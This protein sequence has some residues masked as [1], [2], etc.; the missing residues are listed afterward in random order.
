[1][2]HNYSTTHDAKKKVFNLAHGL[3]VCS[4]LTLLLSGNPKL[5]A[6]LHFPPCDSD[7]LVKILASL[8]NHK[9]CTEVLP[10]LCERILNPLMPGFNIETLH[11]L[12][13]RVLH[14]TPLFLH[15]C[16]VISKQPFSFVAVYCVPAAASFRLQLA[17]DACFSSV[18]NLGFICL[19]CCC[20]RWWR[21]TRQVTLMMV[22]VVVVVMIMLMMTM[23]TSFYL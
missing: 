3:T 17:R 18:P 12:P 14:S 8:P 15:L 16:L 1:M 11:M 13:V 21:S 4:V 19:L 22:V 5:L 20:L 23:M 7:R 6:R 2:Q 9:Q 10:I